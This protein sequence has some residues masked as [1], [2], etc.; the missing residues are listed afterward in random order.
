MR[1]GPLRDALRT[2]A[3]TL[4]DRTL[5]HLGREI[6]GGTVTGGNPRLRR[7]VLHSRLERARRRGDEAAVP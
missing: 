4:L 6:D 5:P 2:I 3:A 7:L 1:T